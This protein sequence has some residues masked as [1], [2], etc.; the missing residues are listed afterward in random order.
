MHRGFV[1]IFRN[2]DEWCLYKDSRCVHML[3]HLMTKATHETQT[4]FFNGAKIDIN[5]G[6]LLTGREQLSVETGIPQTSI[7]RI[8][9]KLEKVGEIEQRK[10]SRNR[11]I[12]IK[13]WNQFQSMRTTNGQQ[14]D[15]ERTTSGQ[16]T[17][18]YKNDKNDENIKNDKKETTA[19]PLT[20]VQNL[21]ELMFKLSGVTDELTRKTNFARQ[22]RYAK[23]L[24]DE[25]GLVLAVKL[26]HAGHETFK[27]WKNGEYAWDLQTILKRHGELKKAVQDGEDRERARRVLEQ[28]KRD[29]AERE[30]AEERER[31][32]RAGEARGNL[33][34]LS[35]IASGVGGEDDCI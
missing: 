6:C 13:K 23:Q 10:T 22:T 17:D 9:G 19:K 2:I 1:K 27:T 30:R 35:A 31:S 25:D 4:I 15:N 16:Q 14:T 24:I 5:E 34:K 18:T 26:V 11:L 7:E 3:I 8:L 12:F 21:V 32:A 33:Q 28:G 29:R 20:D